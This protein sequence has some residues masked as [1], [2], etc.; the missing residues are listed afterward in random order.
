MFDTS[1]PKV[2]EHT[3]VIRKCIMNIA[4]FHSNCDT[5]DFSFN[6]LSTVHSFQVNPEAR[7]CL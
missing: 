1:L 5:I 2:H 7:Q 4:I 6:V 3:S